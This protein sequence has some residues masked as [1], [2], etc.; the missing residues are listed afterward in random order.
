M[1]KVIWDKKTGG[2]QLVNKVLPE[3]LGV[4]PRPV[5]FEELDLLKLNELGWIYPHCKEPLLWACNKQY[6]YRGDF[7]FEVKGA[8]LYNAPQVLLQPGFEH[9]NLKPV[10]VEAM[11]KQCNDYMF[12]AESEAIE[13]IRDTYLQYANA[14]HSVEKVKANQMD[15]EALAAKAEKSLKQKMAIVKQD[16]DSFDIMPLE[17]AKEE[18]KKCI[19]PQ[20]LMCFLLRSLEERIVRWCL[21]FAPVPYH[22]PI[23]K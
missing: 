11:L 2:V 15:F 21:T 10:D 16:C 3:T 8:N 12:L 18:G 22:L 7:V 9:L 4:S 19:K 20:K 17:T 23:S 6:F 1:F 5:F 14:R 13:F